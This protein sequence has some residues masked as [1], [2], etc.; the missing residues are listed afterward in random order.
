M[1][2]R[3]LLNCSTSN[4]VAGGDVENDNSTY[5]LSADELD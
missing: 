4:L 3:R 5:R 1:P 2:R